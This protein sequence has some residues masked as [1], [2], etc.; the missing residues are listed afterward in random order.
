MA[1]P[2]VG[3]IQEANREN[4]RKILSKTGWSRYMLF[5]ILAVLLWNT[6]QIWMMTGVVSRVDKYNQGVVDEVGGLV[7]DVKLF[8]DDLNGI[9]RFLLLPEKQYAVEGE[10]G[11]PAS[12]DDQTGPQNN[13]A[14]FAFLDSLVKDQK[15]E[16]NRK[17]AQPVFDAL[18]TNQDFLTRMTAAKLLFG[19]KGDLQVKFIDGNE[20]L[21]D[22]TKNELFG[23]P[24]Y[25]LVF[26]AG[27][28]IFL[29]QSA[30]GESKFSDYSKADFPIKLA[31]SLQKNL[32]MVRDAKLKSLSVAEE[33]EKKA[34]GLVE[35]ELQKKKQELDSI[36]KDKAFVETLASIGLK[37]ATQ[38]R[39]E[40]NKYIYDVLDASG[41]VK[42]SLALEISSGM[43]KV[44]KDNQEI[45][46]KSF[47]ADQD[48]SKKNF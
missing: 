11:E 43:I 6:F 21:A 4:V 24:L 39:E 34:Q 45:D 14:V 35:Q 9:R 15:I 31:D 23:K 12:A 1:K 16:E 20:L 26:D 47:L 8:A 19:E 25:D 37:S 28:N 36:V 48:G 42:F 22:G 29:L 18:F 13:V 33:E 17:A 46:I 38:A 3:K 40:N 32:Q 10:S 2:D 27:N 41:K 5:F 30:I 44:L 7:G